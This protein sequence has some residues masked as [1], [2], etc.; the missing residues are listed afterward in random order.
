MKWYMDNRQCTWDFFEASDPKTFCLAI[1]IWKIKL[2]TIISYHCQWIE[3]FLDLLFLLMK[4]EIVTQENNH[5]TEWSI[6]LLV[7]AAIGLR[8]VIPVPTH[9]TVQNMIRNKN[10]ECT[11]WMF[12]LIRVSRPIRTQILARTK[13]CLPF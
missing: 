5:S 11:W 12:L 7:Y 2:V 1:S 13:F 10:Q 3:T 6:L 8:N 4:S 9:F